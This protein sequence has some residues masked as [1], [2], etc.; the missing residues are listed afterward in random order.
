L[1]V[2]L[3]FLHYFNF[4]NDTVWPH[5]GVDP[6]KHFVATFVNSAIHFF[7]LSAV[8]LLSMISGWL[9][10]S[11]GDNAPIKTVFQKRIRSR[12]TSL[13]MPLVF[14]N[15]LYVVAFY[16]IYRS[17]PQFPL[18][19]HLN[20]NFNTAGWKEYVNGVFALTHRPIAFQFWFVRDLLV[21]VLISPL[22]IL[23]SRRAPW[24]GAIALAIAWICGWSMFI[25]LR[26]DVPFFFYLGALVRVK[27]LPTAMSRD[28]AIALLAVFITIVC[29]RV[30]APLT[31]DLSSNIIP[32]WLRT[33]T[34]LMRC[35]GVLACWGM[36]QHIAQTPWGNTIG[37]YSGLAF[38]LF[39]AHWPLIGFV[40]MT[41]W[42]LIPANS[43]FWMLIHH[44]ACV[45]LTLI[46]S[47]GIG[48]LLNRYVPAVFALLN[49]GRLLG[50]TKE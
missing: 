36:L 37:K 33:T 27:Q 12:F 32:A 19:D 34:S 3:V 20:L 45:S 13:Y 15:L 40:K 50:Q 11:F 49:G 2:G 26:P 30:L 38:F 24:L 39:A 23:I 6:N 35:V 46:M 1:I 28:T 9:F 47:L 10:F 42:P 8:P 43:D 41:L 22:L 21:T 48:I 14:W 16:M 44:L 4:P 17:D 31:I 29:I 18:L 7:F 25:F 5:I